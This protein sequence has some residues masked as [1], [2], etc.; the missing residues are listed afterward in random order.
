MFGGKQWSASWIF[1]SH[2]SLLI[3]IAPVMTEAIAFPAKHNRKFELCSWRFCHLKVSSQIYSDL[4]L[5]RVMFMRFSTRHQKLLTIRIELGSCYGTR[6]TIHRATIAL[7]KMKRPTKKNR[8][9]KWHNT[10]CGVRSQCDIQLF[11]SLAMKQLQ[12]NI[13]FYFFH[14][15]EYL[16]CKCVWCVSSC[17]FVLLWLLPSIFLHT[18]FCF[19]Q[20]SK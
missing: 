16:Q 9:S 15:F 2:F 6:R 19:L 14:S 11:V 1:L 3:I 5:S 20:I 13:F 4:E 12:H 7:K 8:N 18:G 10:R 17:L